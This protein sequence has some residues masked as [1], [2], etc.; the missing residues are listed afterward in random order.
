MAFANNWRVVSAAATSSDDRQNFGSS[1]SSSQGQMSA[2]LQHASLHAGDTDAAMLRGHTCVHHSCSCGTTQT[3]VAGVSTVRQ[4]DMISLNERFCSTRSPSLSTTGGSVGPP[5]PS[6]AAAALQI[7][8]SSQQPFAL[9]ATSPLAP[10]ASLP[11]PM[12]AR[13]SR[14]GQPL[15]PFLLSAFSTRPRPVHGADTASSC[16]KPQVA[17]PAHTA[18]EFPCS[19]ETAECPVV[20]HLIQ[21]RP[22][23][24]GIHGCVLLRCLLLRFCMVLPQTCFRHSR[25]GKHHAGSMCRSPLRTATTS[26]LKRR[27]KVWTAGVKRFAPQRSTA[28]QLGSGRGGQRTS[29]P[30]LQTGIKPWHR[31]V[32]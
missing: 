7:A 27:Y 18:R 4:K 21:S 13:S 10:S 20:V 30:Q 14:N 23:C 11:A 32:P 17:L 3:H 2:W 26:K 31:V 5:S 25:S 28:G 9:P 16:H 12:S 19:F 15:L 22:A 8:S 24:S 1:S 6:H 29:T